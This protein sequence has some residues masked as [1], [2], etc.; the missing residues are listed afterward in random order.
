M[1]RPPS[2]YVRDT[3]ALFADLNV[4]LA[5]WLQLPELE[6]NAVYASTTGVALMR[7]IAFCMTYSPKGTPVL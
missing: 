6:G 5:S 3:Y 7:F 1:G 4:E 2:A